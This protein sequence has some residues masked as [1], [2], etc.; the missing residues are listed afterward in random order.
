MLDS[1]KKLK[2]SFWWWMMDWQ[3][4]QL[5]FRITDRNIFLCTI[6]FS[7][8][9]FTAHIGAGVACL[10]ALVPHCVLRYIFS[11]PKKKI[12]IFGKVGRLSWLAYKPA[13]QNISSL[14]TK[15]SLLCMDESFSIWQ[16][17]VMRL[18]APSLPE[19]HVNQQ[20]FSPIWT[21]LL[22]ISFS[23]AFKAS[24]GLFY[25]ITGKS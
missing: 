7:K 9:R 24:G 3:L 4:G 23:W 25:Y 11:H 15:V 2:I 5:H 19:T 16:K 1:A 20:Q 13:L 18:F 6:R 12:H 17:N 22:M 21:Q 8:G 14:L 10:K